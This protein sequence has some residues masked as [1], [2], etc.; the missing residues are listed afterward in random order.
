M[1]DPLDSPWM[2]LT[3][4]EMMMDLVL[5]FEVWKKVMK[6]AKK[7]EM[8]MYQKVSIILTSCYFCQLLLC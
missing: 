8:V 7:M 1:I 2:F 6:M 5:A 3:V 4:D